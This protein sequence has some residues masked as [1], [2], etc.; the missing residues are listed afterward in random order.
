MGWALRA[1]G[2]TPWSTPA[3]LG[4]EPRVA[5]IRLQRVKWAGRLKE[6]VESRGSS[7]GE[8]RGEIDG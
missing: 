2:V 3:P 8:W 5:W 4:V 6:F 1:V 7:T